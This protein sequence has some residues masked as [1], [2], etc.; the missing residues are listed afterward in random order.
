MLGRDKTRWIIGSFQTPNILQKVC[1][2]LSPKICTTESMS[3]MVVGLK[4]SPLTHVT[5]WQHKMETLQ[6]CPAKER[7]LMMEVISRSQIRRVQALQTY[8]TRATKQRRP[9]AAL[10]RP[11]SKLTS[12]TRLHLSDPHSQQHSRVLWE[13]V[14]GC[15]SGECQEFQLKP[16]RLFAFFPLRP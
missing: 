7:L 3:G 16:S 14:Q 13:S 9:L 2:R 11:R 1:P 10:F 8:Q 5:C 12:A 15:P 6:V 4:F